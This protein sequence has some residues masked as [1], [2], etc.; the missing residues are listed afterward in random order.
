MLDRRLC[1]EDDRLLALWYRFAR[2]EKQ[3]HSSPRPIQT[4]ENAR[5]IIGLSCSGCPVPA[6]LELVVW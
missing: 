1:G 5:H 4:I 6:N 2:L 3:S